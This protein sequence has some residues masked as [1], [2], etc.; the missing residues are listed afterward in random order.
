MLQVYVRVIALLTVPTIL[1]E[2][3]GIVDLRS[4][5]QTHM[6]LAQSSSNLDP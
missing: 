5:G 6:R 1:V 4:L 2:S 3:T